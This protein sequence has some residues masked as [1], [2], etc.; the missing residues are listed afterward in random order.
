MKQKFACW[1]NSTLALSS[2]I[3]ACSLT[4]CGGSDDTTVNII[5]TVEA[6]DEKSVDEQTVVNL[7]GSANDIDGTIETYQW[8]QTSGTSVVIDSNTSASASFDAP[9]VEEDETLTFTLTVTDNDG[10][11]ATDNVNVIIKNITIENTAPIANAGIDQAVFIGSTVTLSGE[12]SSD[13]DGDNINYAWSLS[14]IP[15]GSVSQFYSESTVAPTFTADVIGTYIIHLTVNDGQLN[16]EVDTVEILVTEITVGSTD[17]LLCDYNYSQ[18][19]DSASVLYNSTAQW[20]CSE[21]DRNLIANGIPDHEVGTF[22]NN[23]NPNAIEEQSVSISFDLLPTESSTATTLGGPRGATGYVLNGVKIDAGTAGSCDDSASNCS[24]IE[25]SGNWSIEALGQT[26]F[27]FGT[28]DNNAHVQPGG[29]Y[30]YH[31]MPEGFISKQGGNSTTMTII[32]WA[33]DGF[34]IY[35]RYGYST[36]SDSA[37]ALKSMTGSYQLIITD[38]TTRPSSSIYPLGTFSQDWEYVAGSG[39]L[40][41]CNGRVGVTPEFPNGIYHYF[42]TDSYPYFQRCVKGEVE[43]AGGMPPPP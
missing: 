19:N 18:Y 23:N 16:S 15:N 13:A 11:T 32:G 28:D 4:A 27:N 17:N 2:L 42:A 37:S 22:P 9:A 35:A 34:P 10:G 20:S 40:D 30:H 29:S 33:A 7:M 8:L 1:N 5:P 12:Q 3:L 43:T 14:T 21:G 6:G 24:L 31:G 38:S 25:N 39:D 26:S 41:E 36:A